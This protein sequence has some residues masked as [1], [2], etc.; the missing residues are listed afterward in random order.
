MRKRD[1]KNLNDAGAEIENN[2]VAIQAICNDS[3][4]DALTEIGE[5]LRE[6]ETSLRKA[7]RVCDPE[8]VKNPRLREQLRASKAV[9]GIDAFD[10]KCAAQAYTDTGEAWDLLNEIRNLLRK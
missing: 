6:I 8:G 10:R 4:H 3:G 5:H 9:R 7:Q 2:G 1:W